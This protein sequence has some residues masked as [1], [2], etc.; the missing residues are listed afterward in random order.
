M[1]KVLTQAELQRIVYQEFSDDGEELPPISDVVVNPPTTVDYVSDEE[2]IDDNIQIIND[3]NILPRE[4]AGEFE[5]YFENE[6]EC[7]VEFETTE[8]E[9]STSSATPAKKR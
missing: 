8:P 4:M 1:L 2:E 9:P 7:E 5:I 6:A 3:G